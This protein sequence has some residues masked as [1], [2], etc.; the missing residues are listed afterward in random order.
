MSGR[1][2]PSVDEL[3]ANLKKRM[4]LLPNGPGSHESKNEKRFDRVGV[5][6]LVDT[7]GNTLKAATS[8]IVDTPGG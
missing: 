7:T 4:Y 2:E 6:P 5:K 8:P 1:P 3:R